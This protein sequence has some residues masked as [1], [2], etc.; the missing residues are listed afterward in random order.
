MYGP[1]SWPC[2][3]FKGF[4]PST[5]TSSD[6]HTFPRAFLRVD[7]SQRKPQKSLLITTHG[8][9][10]HTITVSSSLPLANHFPEC[11]HLTVRTGPVCIVSVHND[12]GGLPDNSEAS[13]RIGLVLHI[14]IFASR[15]PVAI[16]D[17]S[18]CT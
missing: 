12:F 10:S 9:W 4:Q 1:L 16:R 13:F 2:S 14:R 18:G 5:L 15:P 8:S 17:P 7:L 6:P 3:R 11:A